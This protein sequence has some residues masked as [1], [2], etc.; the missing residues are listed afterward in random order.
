M[1]YIEYM[2]SNTADLTGNWVNS[3]QQRVH[4]AVAMKEA[5]VSEYTGQV[6]PIVRTACGGSFWVNNGIDNTSKARCPK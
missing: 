5:Y 3:G 4:L 6:T 2:N 1:L